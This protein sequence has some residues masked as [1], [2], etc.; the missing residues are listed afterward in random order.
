MRNQRAERLSDSVSLR[1]SVS[2]RAF[3][4]K[5]S[6]E[7]RLPMG[8]AIRLLIDEAMTRPVTEA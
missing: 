4:E 5:L 2:Q 7:K 1:T 8:E 3:L 6:V